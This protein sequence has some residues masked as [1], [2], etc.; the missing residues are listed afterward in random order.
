MA[1]EVLAEAGL[2][3]EVYDAMPSPARKFLLAGK[4][5]MNITHSEPLPAFIARYGA[6]ADIFAR[7]LA[8]FGPDQLRDWCRG[9][10]IDTFVGTSGRVFPTDFKAAPLLRAWLRRLRAAGVRLHARHRW[11]GWDAAGRA[12]FATPAG[13]VTVAAPATVLALGGASWPRLGSDGGWVPLLTARGIAVAPL[14]PA[15]CGFDFGWSEVFRARFA[16][17]PVKPV[18]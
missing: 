4:G 15:N 17:A 6:R 3:V 12:R 9:L 2:A 14:K 18:V 1:A 16:G 11:L 10:G 7:L 5:G 13:E 8:G